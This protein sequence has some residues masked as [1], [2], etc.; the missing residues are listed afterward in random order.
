MNT[1]LNYLNVLIIRELSTSNTPKLQLSLKMSLHNQASETIMIRLYLIALCCQMTCESFSRLLS[2]I[3]IKKISCMSRCSDNKSY[4]R[5]TLRRKALQKNTRTTSCWF[6]NT[7]QMM[8]QQ[9]KVQMRFDAC[10][11]LHCQE[12]ELPLRQEMIS[13]RLPICFKTDAHGFYKNV[14]DNLWIF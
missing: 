3:K 8:L 1:Y 13:I 12:Y 4:F 7:I 2:S 11:R 6:K 14:G 9:D 10:A 5:A